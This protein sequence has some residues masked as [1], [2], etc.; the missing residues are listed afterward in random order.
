M[1]KANEDE[2]ESNIGGFRG[3]LRGPKDNKKPK[4][5]PEDTD[6]EDDD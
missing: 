1:T 2:D 6:A 5:K 3:L 4:T